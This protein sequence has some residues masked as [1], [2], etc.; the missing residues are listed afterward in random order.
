MYRTCKCSWLSS[1]LCSLLFL[2]SVYDKFNHLC[3]FDTGLVEKNVE[4]FFSGSVKAVY[5]ENPDPSG[6]SDKNM[7]FVWV[8]KCIFK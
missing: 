3:P 6:E 1:L 8:C 4:L 5:D 2:C 7:I